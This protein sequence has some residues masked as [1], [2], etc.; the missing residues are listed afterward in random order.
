MQLLESLVEAGARVV[1]LSDYAEVANYKKELR[2]EIYL[3]LIKQLRGPNL[4]E[5]SMAKAWEKS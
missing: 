1:T 5:E 2:D 4:D 3:Q